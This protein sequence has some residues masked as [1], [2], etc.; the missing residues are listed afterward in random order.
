MLS[1][2]ENTVRV[3]ICEGL[4]SVV[5]AIGLTIP[6]NTGLPVYK[7]NET[8]C[9][10]FRSDATCVQTSVIL[11]GTAS[12]NHTTLFLHLTTQST[13]NTPLLPLTTILIEEEN[14]CI[15]TQN[16]YSSES[17][18]ASDISVYDEPSKYNALEYHN[19]VWI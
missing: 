7:M 18:N 13:Q 4:N 15:E 19:E 8:R 11:L 2:K 3:V 6:S 5:T 9:A 17:S 10:L 1:I 14:K 12:V 16:D